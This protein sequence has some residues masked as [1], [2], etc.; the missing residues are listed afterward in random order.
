MLLCFVQFHISLTPCLYY[1]SPIPLP[2]PR[3]PSKLSLLF[4]SILANSN[5]SQFLHYYFCA[6]CNMATFHVLGCLNLTIIVDD[7][8]TTSISKHCLCT[9][10]M[11]QPRSLHISKD[12]LYDSNNFTSSFLYQNP[13]TSLQRRQ[14]VVGCGHYR[15]VGDSLVH[16]YQETILMARTMK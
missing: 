13:M 3:N 9:M 11:F 16:N 12:V 2:L 4:N 5:P 8:G 14:W 6:L 15:I 1:I 7:L 10:F